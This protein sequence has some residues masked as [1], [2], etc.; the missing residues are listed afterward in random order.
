[1]RKTAI[2]YE[3]FNLRHT[4]EG[5]PENFRRLEGTWQ[6]LQAD[7]IL[8]HLLQAP[9]SPAPLDAVFRVHT[10]QYIERL[11]ALSVRGGGRIDADTY[12]NADSYQAALLAAG[13]LL[14]L[15]DMVLTGQADNGF[16]LIRPP[17]HHAL[18]QR[19]M[20]FCLLA[21]AAIAARW[22]QDHHGVERVLIVDFDV[23]HG[24]GTQAIFY[25][26][27]TVLF[28]S[29][30][31]YPYYPGTGAADEVGSEMAYGTTV[32]VPFPTFVGDSGYLTTFQRLLE[33]VAREFQPQLII[34]SAGFDAHW[35]DPLAGMNLSIEGYMQMVE[36]VMALA[37]ELCAGKL[38]CVLEGGYH[39]EVLA[40]CVLSTLR[41]L[42][43][44]SQ[45][46]SD[47]FGKVD[48][49]ERDIATLLSRLRNLHG[50]KEPPIYSLGSRA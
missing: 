6:L 40:H 30:H 48:Q 44:S 12:V 39:L 22:A 3:P 9:S 24:N 42:S 4:L 45:G 23:H 2:V 11:Q 41:L 28:F 29:T 35:L 19:G 43:G 13:G 17:G 25:D 8:P 31:Q 26:D 7:G 32:N 50:V 5:H 21:N 46:I 38:V 1:M 36:A 18:E 47:P 10:P 33:P 14:N 16:A 37:D 15:T 34:L 27:P 20:G 49:R